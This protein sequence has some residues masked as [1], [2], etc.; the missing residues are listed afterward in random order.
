MQATVPLNKGRVTTEDLNELKQASERN[1]ECTHQMREG[2]EMNGEQV[3]CKPCAARS[4][5][6]QIKSLAPRL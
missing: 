5:L 1:C 4:V 6:N 3:T 2:L